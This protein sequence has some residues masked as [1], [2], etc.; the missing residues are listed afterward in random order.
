MKKYLFAVL[1]VVLIGGA[2]LAVTEPNITD[3]NDAFPWVFRKG[4]YVGTNAKNPSN[5]V[6]NK[7]TYTLGN[8][9]S[10]DFASANTGT[11]YSAGI[12]VTGAAAG[13][14]CFAGIPTGQT[15][16]KAT[17][18]CVVSAADTAKVW[19]APDDRTVGALFLDGG[20]QT[21]TVPVNSICLCNDRDDQTK[22]A[23]C[24]V[25]TTVMTITGTGGDIVNY[26]CVAPVDPDGGTYY[27][28]VISS[29]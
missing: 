7:V 25:S 21:V 22:G 23:K 10:I 16:L 19:F 24:P 26:S 11:S 3:V 6:K 8:S 18:G 15:A 2:A 9:S 13:D 17:F 14:P 4:L 5:N 20:A 27:V 12:T 29:Q 1:A 28:R